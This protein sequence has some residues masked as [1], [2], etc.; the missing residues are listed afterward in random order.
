MNK[1]ITGVGMMRGEPGVRS[2]EVPMPEIK[3][4]NEVLVRMKEVGLDGTDINMVRYNLQDVAEG[5]DRIILGHEG[6]G[7]VEA[8]GKKVK[9]LKAGDIVNV[10]VRRGCGECEPCLN[11]ASDMCMTGRF[12]ERGIHKLDG[13][14]TQYIVDKEMYL[15]K[16]PPAVKKLAVFTE[17]LSIV[18][19]GVEQIRIIQSRLPWY[20]PHDGHSLLDQDWG[21][22]KVALVVG[23][24]PLGLL[25]AALLR[26]SKAYTYVCDIVSEDHPKVKFVNDMEAKYI[27][28]RD[29]T[30]EQI[31]DFCCTPSGILNIIFEASGAAATAL[32]LIPFMS[33][34]SIYVMTGIP[35]ENIQISLDA[36]RLMR[37]IVR[38]NQVIVG[39]VNSNRSHFE[40][41]LADLEKI[42]SSFGGM[43]DRMITRRVPL[44]DYLTAFTIS[45]PNHIKTVVEIE[46]W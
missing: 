6:I 19:K 46:P 41:A 15:V 28:V 12:I 40:M 43:L 21:G 10:L 36:A 20:C 32:E 17:P 42:N 18:E 27:D 39:S 23:A 26:L 38:Y 13:L 31:V 37:Q 44:E 7:V 16:V 1:T 29:K 5:K 24:G 4:P 34:S 33:R 22:C 35:R 2:F 14:L 3:Q 45:D 9:S 25:A 8:V 11:N 30:P